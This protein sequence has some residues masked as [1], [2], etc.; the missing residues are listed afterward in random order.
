MSDKKHIDRLFQEKFKDFNETPNP[1]VWANIEKQLVSNQTTSSSFPSWLKLGSIAAVLFLFISVGYVFFNSNEEVSVVSSDIDQ[2]NNSKIESNGK[3]LNENDSNKNNIL[4]NNSYSEISNS[5]ES[6]TD[7]NSSNTIVNNANKNSVN[8][9]I[10]NN[11]FNKEDYNA[12]TTKPNQDIANVI[13]LKKQSSNSIDET[14]GNNV[15]NEVNNLVNA[16]TNKVSKNYKDNFTGIK[17]KGATN[18]TQT[19]STVVSTNKNS[20][21]IGTNKEKNNG[22]LSPDKINSAIKNNP[23]NYNVATTNSNKTIGTTSNHKNSIEDSNYTSKYS[24]SNTNSFSENLFLNSEIQPLADI[25]TDSIFASL[26]DLKDTKSIEA[27]IAE[28][29]KLLEKE[30]IGKRWAISPNIAPVY[31][32]SFG[33]GSQFHDQ[34]V[35]NKKSGET[36]TSYGITVGYALNKNLKIRTGIHQLNLSYDTDDVFVFESVSNTPNENPLR[37]ITFS[38]QINTQGISVI[39]STNLASQQINSTLNDNFNAALSQRIQYIEVPLELEYRLSKNKFGVNIIGGFSSF[40]LSDNQVVS[41]FEDNN[42]ELGKAN[43]INNLSFST[44]LGIGLNY[45]FSKSFVYNFEPTFKYQ[46]NGFSNTSGNFNPY[47]IGVY[48]GFSYKF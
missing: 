3:I 19:N 25:K 22:L 11:K 28:N 7:L 1:E 27:A 13:T 10:V 32:N 6:N 43:N 5:P 23:N 30:A 41:E 48:T 42:T 33:T 37:N 12:L 2:K 21:S 26:L 45:S 39:S 18:K 16:N 4:E 9:S 31:Y 34:F 38:N 24:V 20:S 15:Q 8:Q 14:N 35:N 40:I 36:N 47:I 44:N 46:I 29:E 17:N